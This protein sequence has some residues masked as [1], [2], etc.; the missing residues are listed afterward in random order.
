QARRL[1]PRAIIVTIIICC[2]VYVLVAVA[3]VHLA[4]LAS[5]NM[6]APLATA[7][8][9]RGATVLEFVVSLGAVGNTMTS[10][11]SSM[12]VQPRIMLRMS[13][14][15]LLPRSIGRL[16]SSGTPSVALIITIV[17][18][19]ALALVIDFEALAD[20]VSFGALL[21]FL[22]VCLCTML[23]RVVPP[24][25]HHQQTSSEQPSETYGKP[26]MQEEPP[27]VA[28]VQ[29]SSP[30]RPHYP[31]EILLMVLFF[32][33]A[34]LIFGVLFLHNLVSI[35][36]C[37][38]F[39]I[40]SLIAGIATARI[41]RT[42]LNYTDVNSNENIDSFRVPGAPEVPLIGMFVNT[43]VH[44]IW[45]TISGSHSR[46]GS[47]ARCDHILLVLLNTKL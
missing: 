29:T 11:M 10:V 37:L 9:A 24:W 13:S 22:A 1:V 6:N 43:Q 38:P 36:F 31:R 28:D 3:F 45:P 16:T 15:G 5:V 4:P 2:I 7:F 12:I 39:L 25:I 32:E 23:G 46:L 33:V 42:Y 19:S 26:G 41:V 8:E 17:V 30:L 20:I 14:D 18:S 44:D 27:R 35:F 34:T 21:S 40:I 47:D